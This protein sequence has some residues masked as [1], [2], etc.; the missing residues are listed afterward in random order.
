MQPDL[1][2]P[3]Q[4]LLSLPDVHGALLAE[5]DYFAASQLLC[6]RWH[7]HLTAGSVVRGAQAALALHAAHPPRRVL[8]DKSRTTG[9]WDEALPWFHYDWLPQVVAGGLQALAY[10]L[11]P[12]PHAQPAAQEF[13]EVARQHL[14]MGLFRE[15]AAAWQWLL[16]QPVELRG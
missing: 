9:S 12:D 4:R 5:F 7:G 1:Y 3:A 2:A 13:R 11:S 8:N 10:V 14:A 15:P 16:R 6:V